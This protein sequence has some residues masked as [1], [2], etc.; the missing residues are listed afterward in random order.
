MTARYSVTQRHARPSAVRPAARL[1][2]AGAVLAALAGTAA[3]AARSL[4]SPQPRAG[5]Q[6]RPGVHGQT[7][8]ETAAQVITFKGWSSTDRRQARHHLDPLSRSTS[9]CRR[10]LVRGRPPS[11]PAFARSD[12]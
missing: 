2:A 10:R 4:P 11:G 6:Q 12:R 3:A 8:S 5:Q 9:A 7:G 1:L